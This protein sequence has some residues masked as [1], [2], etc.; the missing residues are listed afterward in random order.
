[1]TLARAIFAC[2]MLLLLYIVYLLQTNTAIADVTTTT[3]TTT[4]IKHLIVIFQEN[5]SFDHYFATYPKADNNNGSGDP[6]FLAK[7][8]TPSVNGLLAAGLLTNNPNLANPF[9]I[10]R[11]NA[12]TCDN[13]HSYTRLQEA[14]NGGLMD[15]FVQTNSVADGCNPSITMGYFDGN[16]VTALWN[17]AQHFAMSDNFFGSTF[18]SS[19]PG[20]INLIS[21]QTHGAT[22]SYLNTTRGSDN[23]WFVYNSTL[24]YDANPAY[25]N[26]FNPATK[27][28]P[29][30]SF[31]N[32]NIGDL[33][34]SKNITWGWFEGGFK[35]TNRTANGDP[36]CGSA[37]GNYKGSQVTDYLPHHEPFQF[38]KSTANPNHLQPKS[39][40]NIGH[41]DQANHQYDLSDFWNAAESGNNFLPSVSFLKARAFQDG[42]AGYSNPLEEQNFVVQT[43]NRLQKLPDWNN[44]A[45]I[46][47]YDDSD[48]W[49]DHVMPPIV[50]QSN[51]PKNDALLGK[52]GL[53]GHAPVG[54]YQDRCG[55]GP[56][57][58]FLIIS[59]YAKVDYVDHSVIDQSSIIRFIEDNWGLVRIGNQSFDVKAG[60]IN[61]MFDFTNAADAH[62]RSAAKLFLHPGTGTI[63]TTMSQQDSTTTYAMK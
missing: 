29:K 41:T 26:C 42:H 45:V 9:R 38:Y 36:V 23:V 13:D 24:I 18:G 50:S 54:A 27:S 11:S 32:T 55:Y 60:S 37:H 1:M 35:P 4:P 48:G 21:G 2:L 40:D 17:Y 53:C 31:N 10:P 52:D 25:E 44:T 34:N 5:V 49:Y 59:P 22:P 51:E 33:L 39:V 46:V 7:P 8:D 20:A 12:S 30:A 6:S 15:K 63:T 16:T 62:H 28:F 14:Y 58:P 61:N 43:I 19:T 56:R 3:T 47:T 57:L